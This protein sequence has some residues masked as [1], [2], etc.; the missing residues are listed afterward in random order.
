MCASGEAARGAAGSAGVDG[1][2]NPGGSGGTGVHQAEPALTVRVEDVS[3]MTI[4]IVTL[5][6]AGDCAEVDAVASGGKPPY[7]FEWN[8]GVATGARELC[9]DDDGAFT[10]TVEDTPILD[11]E[12]S[13]AGQTATA[14]VTVDVLACGSDAGPD[15]SCD[16]EEALGEITPDILGT[17]MYFGNGASLP[18]G[19]YRIS[20]VDGCLRYEG[21]WAWSVNGLDT[22][23]Y[24]VFAETTANVLAVAPGTL[25]SGF[26]G[27]ALDYPEFD[28]CVAANLALP[29][30]ELDFAGGRLG[31]WQND[32][33]PDDNMPG[34]DGRSPTW[35]LTRCE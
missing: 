17:P 15:D 23:E 12:F 9:A 25:A 32:F 6:C 34:P 19:R 8:D 7:T 10:V 31:I 28:A 3:E 18:A 2:G 16:G 11:D 20:Y 13:Y 22:Y 14:R 26:F 35:Q 27:A 4:E 1:V 29:P 21:P 33:K 30:L 5:A 24:V